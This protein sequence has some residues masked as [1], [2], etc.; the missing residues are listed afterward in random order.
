MTYLRLVEKLA[1]LF[2][3]LYYFFI[4]IFDKQAFIFR[5]FLCKVPVIIYRTDYIYVLFFTGV[6]VGFAKGRRSMD[7]ARTFLCRHKI[8]GDDSKGPMAFVAGKIREKGLTP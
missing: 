2:Q 1:F 8:I 5:H 3:A 7:Y 6:E 4:R